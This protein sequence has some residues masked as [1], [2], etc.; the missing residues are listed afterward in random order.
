MQ[1]GSSLGAAQQSLGARPQ[2]GQSSLA[3]VTQAP[4]QAVSQQNGSARH[5]VAAHSGRTQPGS[6]LGAVQQSLGSGPHSGQSSSAASTHMASQALSQQYG[7]AAH[8]CA[9]HS[10]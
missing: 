2:T 10:G 8:T 9:S 5:T 4:S 1:P 6:S 7:S 3:A